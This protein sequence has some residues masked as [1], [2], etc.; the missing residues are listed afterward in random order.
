MHGKQPEFDAHAA[1]YDAL[2]H[3]PI[4]ERF[5]GGGAAFFYT[6]KRDL[7]RQYFRRRHIDTHG[8]A[9]LDVG[10]GRAELVGALLEDFGRVA[11]CDPSAGMMEAGGLRGKGVEARVQA[12]PARIPFEDARFDFVTAVCVYHHVPAAERGALTREVRRVLKTGGVFAVME[13]NP[14]NPVTRRIVRRTPVDADAVLLTPGETRGLLR[15]NGFAVDMQ[16]YFLYLPQAIYRRMS[17]LESALAKLPLG[18]QYAVF[19]RAL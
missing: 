15:E 12:D 16:S 11:G 18:G 9:Y 17:W 2:L 7:I 8:L 1:A 4:R 10:C 6:R 5:T 19:G 14:Y 3:D 13:H